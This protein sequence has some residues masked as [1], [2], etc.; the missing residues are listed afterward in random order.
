MKELRNQ[1]L[2]RDDQLGQLQVDAYAGLNVMVLLLELHRHGLCQGLFLSR[3]KPEEATNLLFF[4]P[5]YTWNL[6]QFDKFRLIKVV[7]YNSLLN[8][9]ISEGLLVV[10]FLDMV[11]LSEARLGGINLSG[12]KLNYSQLSG[13]TLISTNL[14]FSSLRSANLSNAELMGAN[15]IGSD[16]FQAN[17]SMADLEGANIILADLSMADLTSAKLLDT[18]LSSATLACANLMNADLRG[19][20]FSNA[21]LGYADLT[22]AQLSDKDRTVKW[23]KYT[24]WEDVI[25][26]DQAIGV[27]DELKQ[28]L[29]L[30]RP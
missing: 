2:D 10:E 26:L 24:V 17:L 8:S 15:L 19:A 11:D 4:H 9:N 25:G 29:G 30:D 6:N 23:D 13:T 27:P 3:D 16:L 22:G 14:E 20:N 1:F 5:C 18:N 12:A 28:Q 21:Y 7:S